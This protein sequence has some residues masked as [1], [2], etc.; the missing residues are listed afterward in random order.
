MKTNMLTY[1]DELLTKKISDYDVALDWDK[2]NHTIMLVLRLF[3]ENKEKVMI[4]DANGVASEEEVIEFEDG[5]LL[6]NPQKSQFEEEDYLA[7]L[8]Y[9]GK[10]GMPKAM[11]NGLVDYLR[12]VLDD[13]QSDLLDFLTDETAEVFELKFNNDV[14]LSFVNSHQ[15]K[16]DDSYIPYPTY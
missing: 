5:I 3:A 14:L 16:D 12:V 13:G 1:L 4:D 15:T 9:E 11:L 8:P 2:K 6:F 10:K 7:V